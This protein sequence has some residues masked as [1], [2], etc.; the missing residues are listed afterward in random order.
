M[1]KNISVL[2]YQR[3]T[4]MLFLGTAFSLFDF[5]WTFYSEISEALMPVFKHDHTEDS[6]L[7]YKYF[8]LWLEGILAV[9]MLIT[10]AG[11]WF[12]KRIKLTKI[13]ALSCSLSSFV[14]GMAYVFTGMSTYFYSNAERYVSTLFTLDISLVIVGI[15]GLVLVN[16][17]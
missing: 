3:I 9:L 10:S 5:W 7:K 14:L 17:S 8:G 4:A 16:R 13:L 6:Y 11:L 12:S 1:N 2:K 15:L